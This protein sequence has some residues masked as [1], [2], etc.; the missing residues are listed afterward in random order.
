MRNAKVDAYIERTAPFARPVLERLR[1]AAHAACPDVEETIKWG[2]PHYEHKGIL[3]GTP[4]F[5]AEA[6]VR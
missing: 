2:V 6:T 4:A 1:D 5:K 3:F